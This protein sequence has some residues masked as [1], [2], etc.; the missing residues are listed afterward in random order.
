VRIGIRVKH[1][2]MIKLQ[3]YDDLPDGALV[4]AEVNKTVLFDIKRICCIGNWSDHRAI[5]GKHA[6]KKTAQYIFCL[7]GTH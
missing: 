5:R 1:A 4:I 6:H 3:Y 7:S 2:G